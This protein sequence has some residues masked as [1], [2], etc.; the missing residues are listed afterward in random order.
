MKNF[1]L[2]ILLTSM[3]IPS[4]AK[5]IE[6][7][8]SERQE[9][10]F[11]RIVDKAT[12]KGV[13]GA[14]ITLPKENYTT[15]TNKDGYFELD[16]TIDGTSILSVQKEKYK[17]YSMTIDKET[18]S[19]PLEV[20]IEK[21]NGNELAVDMNMHHL[22]DNSY[23]ENSANAGE[24]RSYAAGP[25]FTKKFSLKNINSDSPVYLVIGSIIGVDTLMAR[26]MNQNSRPNAYATPPQVFFNGNK[27][28]D[29]QINGDGQKIKIP[30]NIIKKNQLN[31][32]TIK[33]GYNVM[34]TEYVDYDDIEFMNLTIEN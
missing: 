11:S 22:G 20:S 3:I 32:V 14:K 27:I 4:Y 29:I 15:K 30:S 23:S 12:G 19:H 17:P 6:G 10:S 7:G 18:F 2:I 1:I 21:S 26:T 8:V 13:G 5:T 24:F 16:T 25:F 28:A 31:E 33:T 34:Q 9:K